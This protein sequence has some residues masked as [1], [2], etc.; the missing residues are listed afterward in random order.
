M[1]ATRNPA[2]IW[3]IASACLATLFAGA[4]AHPLTT[5]ETGVIGCERYLTR[6]DR[7]RIEDNPI[8]RAIASQPEASIAGGTSEIDMLVLSG[9]GK[10]G[11][12]GAGFLN[13]WSNAEDG[14]FVDMAREDIDIVTGVSTGALLATFAS[15]GNGVAFNNPQRGKVDEEARDQY[16]TSD[17]ELLKELSLVRAALGSNGIADIRDGLE[18]IVG[19][20]AS[21]YRDEMAALQPRQ[22]TLVGLANLTNGAFYFADLNEVAASDDPN[23][24]DCYRE[25]ILGSAAVPAQFPPRFI[26]GH[27]YVDG[28]VRFGA[29]LGETTRD[30]RRALDNPDSPTPAQ[31][32]QINLRVIINGTL[33]ANNPAKDP[34]QALACEKAD[35]D[36][37]ETACKP[38]DNKLLA[39]AARS[40]GEILVDQIY[41]DS[42]FRLERDLKT[43]GLLK[44]SAYTYVSLEE[45]AARDLANGGRCRA[46]T[47]DTFD[48]QFMTCLYNI[49]LEKGE[50]QRWTPFEQMPRFDRDQGSRRRIEPDEGA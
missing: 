46:A 44:S 3:L 28:G 21:D 36:E 27:P 41:R 13:G 14:G 32:I 17:D 15:V 16:D 29:F 39:I 48:N 38:V 34:H 22:K 10:Y 25:I 9:G 2:S 33:S 42:V 8:L 30:A 40:A 1:P 4:C 5:P 35:L 20:V 12:Y 31:N 7:G 37:L 19:K 6:A 45:I 43:M 49:G 26:D 18:P 47:D 50:T 23:A 11:A 24:T